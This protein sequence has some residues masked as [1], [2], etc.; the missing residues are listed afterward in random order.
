MRFHWLGEWGHI[1]LEWPQRQI[2]YVL[3]ALY[4][5]LFF[6]LLVRMVR[7]YYARRQEFAGKWVSKAL[8]LVAWIIFG[9]LLSN[10]VKLEWPA[11]NLPTGIDQNRE[12]I[13]SRSKQ[14]L[15]Q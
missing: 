14:L 4:T 9:V 10:T 8:W 7:E 6:V 3:L 15:S 11:P 1:Y 12:R 2:G 5:L 13:Y